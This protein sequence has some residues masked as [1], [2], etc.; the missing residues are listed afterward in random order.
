MLFLHAVFVLRCWCK[1]K[2]VFFLF[3]IRVCFFLNLVAFSD[4][5]VAFSNNLV[6][7]SDN[8]VSFSDNLVPFSNNLV[9]FSDNLV[10][11]LDCVGFDKLSL[12]VCKVIVLGVKD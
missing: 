10:L 3:Y 9:P 8:L 1:F 5:L 6:P 11:E 7:F 12:T 2:Y 4:N